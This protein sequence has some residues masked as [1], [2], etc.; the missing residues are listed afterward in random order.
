MPTEESEPDSPASTG[1]PLSSPGGDTTA[2]T[3]AHKLASALGDAPGAAHS[4]STASANDLMAMRRAVQVLVDL[5]LLIGQSI[6][7]CLDDREK[8][9]QDLKALDMVKN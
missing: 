3:Q 9:D 4:L 5:E 1:L 8:V 6:K 7:Q 2:V